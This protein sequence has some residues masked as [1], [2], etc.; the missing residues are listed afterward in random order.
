MLASGRSF[1][2]IIGTKVIYLDLDSVLFDL[3]G[4]LLNTLDDL[5]AAVNYALA[6][7]AMPACT[8][9]E[10]RMFV[11]NGVYRL[12][13][14]ASELPEGEKLD[15]C[16]RIFRAY[17]A[18]H[19][20]VMT[21][22]YPGVTPLL[23]LCRHYFPGLVDVAVGE[24]GGVLPKPDPSGALAAIKRLGAKRALYVGDSDVDVMTAHNAGLKCLGVAWGFRSYESLVD[25]G[26]DAV[27]RDADE[28]FAAMRELS[29]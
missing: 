21:R 28:F 12:I 25:A 16:V 9:E 8:V 19:M 7:Y 10:V 22:P 14:R 15:M 24:G 20:T 13:Q 11:G 27:I 1:P 2:K 26:A 6:Q 29:L 18:D 17:Y 3:D 23:G 4:T 5:A